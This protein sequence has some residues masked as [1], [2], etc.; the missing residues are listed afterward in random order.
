M[1]GPGV[2]PG[3]PAAERWEKKR[4]VKQSENER[5]EWQQ[6]Y[7]WGQNE[8]QR[9]WN[10]EWGR[11]LKV[12]CR[13]RS[14]SRVPGNTSTSTHTSIMTHHGSEKARCQSEQ[15][16]IGIPQ[17]AWLLVLHKY[18]K[19]NPFVLKHALIMV[20]KAIVV[21]TLP[22]FTASLNTQIWK[23]KEK[24]RSPTG[25]TQGSECH[26]YTFFTVTPHAHHHWRTH[27][28]PELFSWFSLHTSRLFA[29]VSR[30]WSH[31]FAW[32]TSVHT[33][34]RQVSRLFFITRLTATGNLQCSQKKDF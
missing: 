23:K 24:K 14:S 5:M 15:V 17:E 33:H 25:N 30:V 3:P 29:R 9:Q 10:T 26:L 2:L 4:S 19:S 6:N 16:P 34:S 32:V 8:S 31:R 11:S 20:H 12:I 13:V 7:R 18:K 27:L 1:H 28:H 22:L 21:H